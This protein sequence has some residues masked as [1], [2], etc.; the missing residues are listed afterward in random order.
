ML[1]TTPHRQ[2]PHRQQHPN[3]LQHYLQ[4]LFRGLLTSTV[5]LLAYLSS[6]ANFGPL[7]NLPTLWYLTTWTSIHQPFG[8]KHSCSMTQLPGPLT[9]GS[10]TAQDCNRQPQWIVLRL[11]T[12]L[13]GQPWITNDVITNLWTH[14]N[15]FPWSNGRRHLTF[16]S[17]VSPRNLRRSSLPR[18]RF[19]QVTLTSQRFLGN[20]PT[21]EMSALIPGSLQYRLHRRL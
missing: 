15:G 3:R 5:G 20:L 8:S 2:R 10:S 12:S 17:S 9:M 18:M 16:S 14:R 7:P 13:F 6:L 19:S 1:R 21:K 11:V 4:K